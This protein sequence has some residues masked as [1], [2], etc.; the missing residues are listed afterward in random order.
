MGEVLKSEMQNRIRGL[1]GIKE[2]QVELVWD[3]P[4]DQSRISQSAKVQL[5]MV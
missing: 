4:W 2:V 5:G 3:P 1:P